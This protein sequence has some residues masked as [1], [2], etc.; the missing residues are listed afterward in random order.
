MALHVPCSSSPKVI[1]ISHV[2]QKNAIPCQHTTTNG[3]LTALETNNLWTNKQS[4]LDGTKQKQLQAKKLGC[5]RHA[6]DKRR[7]WR[8]GQ[9]HSERAREQ[10]DGEWSPPHNCGLPLPR[11]KWFPP[12]PF[13]AATSAPRH[14]S[15]GSPAPSFLYTPQQTH[16]HYTHARPTG[17]RA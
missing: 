10:V 8:R 17:R 9:G 3:P 14:C 15:G 7:K 12:A 16:R 13:P 4:N 11:T 6:C 5:I 1:S 2:Q